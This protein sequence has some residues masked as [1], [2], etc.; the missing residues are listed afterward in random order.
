MRTIQPIQNQA[1]RICSL[2]AVNQFPKEKPGKTSISVQT[3]SFRPAGGAP[4]ANKHTD[5]FLQTK[6]YAA[7]LERK[8]RKIA[9]DALSAIE[10]SGTNI[11]YPRL[12][13]EWYEDENSSEK[14]RAPLLLLPVN[15]RGVREIQNLH[16]PLLTYLQRRRHYT[17][18]VAV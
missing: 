18:S 13:S 9:G 16:L 11:L 12:V 10:E 4:P 15:L 3:T 5:Q 14:N 8:L 2:A 1:N 7:D 6:L 17:Q